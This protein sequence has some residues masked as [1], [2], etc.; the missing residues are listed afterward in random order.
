FIMAFLEIQGWGD[1]TFRFEAT[2]FHESYRCRI[3]ERYV[4]GTIA[5]GVLNETEDSCCH[6]GEKYAIKIRGTF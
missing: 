4:G 1:L 6:A 5:T 2:N 3:R